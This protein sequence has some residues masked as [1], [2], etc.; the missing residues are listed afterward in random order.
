MRS[1]L[2]ARAGA[3][4]LTVALIVAA[5]V[6]WSPL[7]QARPRPDGFAVVHTES[8]RVFVHTG[9]VSLRKPPDDPFDSNFHKMLAANAGYMRTT[10]QSLSATGVTLATSNI[11]VSAEVDPNIDII[12]NAYF[13]IDFSVSSAGQG[14]VR[15]RVADPNGFTYDIMFLTRTFQTGLIYRWRITVPAYWTDR[16]RISP[17]VPVSTGFAFSYPMTPAC[18]YLSGGQFVESNSDLTIS[19]SRST[20]N[21]TH[22]RWS[23]TIGFGGSWVGRL[24]H[25]C[26]VR[27]TQG[28]LLSDLNQVASRQITSGQLMIVYIDFDPDI[29]IAAGDTVTVEVWYVV[30]SA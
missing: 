7:A 23:V 8:G 6:W 24:V 9:Y 10:G 27:T 1:R 15:Y 21:S 20:S 13:S 18:V 11:V 12:R 16:I 19:V 30:S 3:V 26:V 25:Y 5:F 22:A 2:L 4:L 29:T 17:V 14:T 28:M